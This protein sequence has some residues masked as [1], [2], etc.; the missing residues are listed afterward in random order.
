[1]NE[2]FLHYIWKF[3]LLD[4]VALRT[5]DGEAIQVVHPGTHNT[6]AGPDFF[7]SKVRIGETLWVGNVEIH[8]RSSDWNRH[9]HSSDEAYNNVILHVVHEDDTMIYNNNGR[10]LSTI[11]IRDKFPIHLKENYVGLLQ[12]AAWVPC[13]SSFSTVAQDKFFMDSY[14]ERVLISRLEQKSSAICN[15]LTY[16]NN[17]WEE[18]FYWSLARSFGFKTNAEPFELL[19]RSIPLAIINKHRESLFQIE[20]LLFGQAGFLVRDSRDGYPRQLYREYE[21]LRKKY[22]LQP[23]AQQVWKFLR[24][25]PGNF[26]TLRIAQFAHLLRTSHNLFHLVREFASVRDLRRQHKVEASPYWDAHYNFDRSVKKSVRKVLGNN[27]IDSLLINSVAPFLFVYGHINSQQ[28]YKDKSLELLGEI[29]AEINNVVNGWKKLG[30]EASS[31]F[32]SQ[33][34]LQLRVEYCQKKKCLSCGI[35]NRILKN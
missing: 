6:D 32:Y 15:M 34:L 29:P 18:C 7:N 2:E 5:A 12:S 26:P 17:N 21:L 9:D 20:A 23:H 13:A 24:L 4:H 35:G 14:L 31:A 16:S 11:Q 22:K 8:V 28:E 10:A 33:A 3:Q 19:A 25:R 27:S 1:M 30:Y